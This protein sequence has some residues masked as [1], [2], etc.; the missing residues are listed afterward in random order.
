[1]KASIQV[2]MSAISTT[3]FLDPYSTSFLSKNAWGSTSWA[4]ISSGSRS[5]RSTKSPA[6][7]F[8]NKLIKDWSI[9]R[10][11]HKSFV[12]A[13][14]R[15]GH[16]SGR[17]TVRA[18]NHY[19]Q[20]C[21][22]RGGKSRDNRRTIKLDVSW[23]NQRHNKRTWRLGGRAGGTGARG[24]RTMSWIRRTRWMIRRRSHF[25]VPATGIL[26]GR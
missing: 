18:P 8:R 23:N 2:T 13:W 15:G 6:K 11:H 1:M 25:C 16:R 22:G 20:V 24:C 17:A 7:I 12:E 19:R 5:A 21:G 9:A 4:L 26:K 14:K 10:T 3:P